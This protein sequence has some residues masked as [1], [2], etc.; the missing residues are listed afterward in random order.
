MRYK[1]TL[2]VLILL[3]FLVLAACDS[4]PSEPN[5]Q[6]DMFGTLSARVNGELFEYQ[7]AYSVRESGQRHIVG[8][9]RP[10]G[11]P[12]A[13]GLL[14]APFAGTGT[15]T[16]GEATN[17]NGQGIQVAGFPVFSTEFEGGTGTIVV[18]EEMPRLKGTFSFTA[19]GSTTAS[20]VPVEV[21]VTE[22]QFDVPRVD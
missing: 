4:S 16:I 19:R 22:G 1:P 9:T 13:I 17:H 7:Y 14:L 2:P 6:D 18:T 12:P 20:P 3:P 15:Y 11:G 5:D 21:V 10:E 8:T